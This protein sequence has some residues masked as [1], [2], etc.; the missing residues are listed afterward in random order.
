M[1]RFAKRIGALPPWV[2]F[3]CT[4]AVTAIAYW[5]VEHAGFVWDD[6][7]T[8]L[9]TA[10]LRGGD[11]WRF[12]LTGVNGWLN[13]FRPLVLALYSAEIHLF[14]ATPMPL[15]FV[16]LALHL[17]NTLLVGALAVRL[18]PD[19]AATHSRFVIA[20]A[21][22][23]Y[24]L[25]PALVEPVVWISC[26]YD[27]VATLFVLLAL[28]SNLVVA[29]PAPRALAVASC[30]FFA[31]CAKES[32]ACL[33]LLLALFDAS[34][35]AG[36]R[37]DRDALQR[38]WRRQRL[39]YAGVLIAGIVYLA[40]RDLALG[41]LVKP[42]GGEHLFSIDHFQKICYTYL[43]YWRICLWPMAGLG[44]LHV[45]D[46]SRFVRHDIAMLGIDA[47]SALIAVSGTAAF[48]KGRPIGT[49]ILA[50]TFALAPVL[51]IVPTLF[52]ES[53]YHERYAMLAIAM[54]AVWLPAAL[55]AS[56]R[57]TATD[58]IPRL[59]FALAVS[60]WLIAA[61]FNVRVTIPLWADELDLWQWAL[62]QNPDSL[63]AQDHLLSEYIGRGD[64]VRAR[65]LA[66]SLLEDKRRCANC[67]LNVAYLAIADGDAG[68]AAQALARIRNEGM[69]LLYEPRLRQGFMLAT[70]ELEALNGAFADAEST[71]HDAIAANP[72]DPAPHAQLA[73]LLARQGRLPEARAA[74]DRAIALFAPAER[75]K[76]RR[77]LEEAIQA[78]ASAAP[79]PR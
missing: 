65:A 58:S 36:A 52:V 49:L 31:A 17:A 56:V 38:L 18:R 28:W 70:G 42:V 79:A 66:T 41:H 39:V 16:S 1:H 25:H 27:L 34:A 43:A 22:L 55:P 37:V 21:M 6:K 12:L 10:S 40:L 8:F 61:A 35:P 50:F 15:H 47:A 73:Y 29:R 67:L 13:Y 68:R 57:H 32:A 77:L 23:A 64:L 59:A 62:H 48:L 60:A 53:L 14:G 9:E 51:N 5:P 45:V 20:L 7:S 44:P 33:P 24:G 69:D 19:P 2:L 11:W 71:F 72:L 54:A 4:L 74:A 26:Q 78:A 46:A 76:N 75:A 30:F 63:V 3:A